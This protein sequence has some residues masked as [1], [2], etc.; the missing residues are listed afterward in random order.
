MRIVK[1]F[2]DIVS[3]GLTTG[4]FIYSNGTTLVSDSAITTNGSGT[5]T[6]QNLTVNASL[7]VS[8]GSLPTTGTTMAIAN[9]WAMP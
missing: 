7:S 6:C 3:F 8:G 9:G 2:I 1:K 4:S 5:L